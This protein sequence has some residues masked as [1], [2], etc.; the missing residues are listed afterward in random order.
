[1]FSSP[2]WERIAQNVTKNYVSIVLFLT[3]HFL[4]YPYIEN[5]F[6]WRDLP[7]KLD[8]GMISE[9]FDILQW[10]LWRSFIERRLE[11]THDQLHKVNRLHRLFRQSRY[12]P[13][14]RQ[15]LHDLALWSVWMSK[16]FSWIDTADR[17]VRTAK[18]IIKWCQFAHWFH[19]VTFNL[20]I[21]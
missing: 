13:F 7:S 12:S 6:T 9:E 17:S 14:T 20:K 18:N 15:I 21:R 5:K 4:Q 19:I 16:F 8:W 2:L 10:H 11:E 3:L 1:M